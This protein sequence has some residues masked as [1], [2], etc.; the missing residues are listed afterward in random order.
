M[1]SLL[2]KNLSEDITNRITGTVLVNVV[3]KGNGELG[4]IR[5]VK[6]PSESLA[7]EVFRVLLSAPKW[8]VYDPSVNWEITIPFKLMSQRR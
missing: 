2:R 3:I 8:T 4:R 6:T 5:V 1:V 7:K